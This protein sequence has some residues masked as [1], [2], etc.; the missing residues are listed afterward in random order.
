L[1]ADAQRFAELVAGAG[2][3]YVEAGL[4]HGTNVG[5]AT[6][7]PGHVG[8][9]FNFD[10][11]DDAI[12]VGSQVGLQVQNFTIEGWVRRAHASRATQGA[13][14]SASWF[15]GSSGAYGFGMLDD[16][17]LFLTKV[18]VSVVISAPWCAAGPRTG[19]GER[20]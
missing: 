18:G 9:A 15:S 4:A 14:T 20:A 3:A 5:N 13:Q 12:Q 16:G 2:N 8:Q 6:F 10:G 19:R 11:L 7:G 17:R 1:C